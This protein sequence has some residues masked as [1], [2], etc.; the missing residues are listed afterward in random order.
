MLKL[1]KD[2]INERTVFYWIENTETLEPI[3]EQFRSF[4]Q[5]EEWWKGH[6][7]TLFSGVERRKTHVDRRQD[8]EKREEIDQG[9]NLRSMSSSSGRRITDLQDKVDIDLHQAKA[10]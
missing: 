8:L 10:G 2:Y 5:A 6:M 9:K 4:V 3:S 7:F 1:V